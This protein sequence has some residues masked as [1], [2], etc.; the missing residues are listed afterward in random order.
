MVV[1]VLA[2]TL[3]VLTSSACGSGPTSSP[4][5]GGTPVVQDCAGIGKSQTVAQPCCEAFGIDACGA[6]LFCAAFDGRTQPTCYI[7][8]VR[9][10]L[11]TCTEDRQCSTKHCASDAKQCIGDGSFATDCVTDG[12]CT[13]VDAKCVGN[14]CRWSVGHICESSLGYFNTQ[15]HC[16]G[17]C[18]NGL[19]ALSCS[20]SKPCSAPS[21]ECK[22]QLGGTCGAKNCAGDADCPNGWCDHASIGYF[23]SMKGGCLPASCVSDGD[24]VNGSAP[25]YGK[26]DVLNN[27][28][29]A[30]GRCTFDCSSS[31]CIG[32]QRCGTVCF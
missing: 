14:E 22:T 23:S 18:I 29:C 8:G 20:A 19:C 26:E 13:G 5:D 3:M 7:E 1:E 28:H 16:S 9:K 32:T 21:S 11:E 4:S 17:P 6:S 24:C 15:N 30:N 2:A 31:K 27:P 10:A 25:Y 12:E